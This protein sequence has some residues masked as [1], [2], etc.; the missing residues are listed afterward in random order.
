M[1]LEDSNAMVNMALLYFQGKYVKFN[2]DKASELF[3]RAAYY[4][5]TK[6]IEALRQAR[7]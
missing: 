5:N 4:G 1:K 2:E 3:K 7:K 6:A